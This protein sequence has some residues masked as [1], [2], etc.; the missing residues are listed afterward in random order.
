LSGLWNQ[1]GVPH[2]GWTCID[3]ED[4]EEPTATCEMCGK[5]EIRFVHVME[6]R[7]RTEPLRV[8]C[9]C[10]EKMS[11]DYVNPRRREEALKNRARRRGNWLKRKW[12][13][14]RNGNP[15][16]NVD[17]VNVTVFTYKGRRAGK[18]GFKVADTF[19]DEAFGQIEEAKLAAFDL[20]WKMTNP[21]C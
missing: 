16:L 6:H 8:G 9:I 19:G 14:S 4:L 13:I 17:G 21:D 12:R 1:A 18:W 11:E 20:F 2:R 3:V 7:E 5:E 15:F 10:A